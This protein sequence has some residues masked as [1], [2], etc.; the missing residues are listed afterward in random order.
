[1][2]S[3]Q[4]FICMD[5]PTDAN[6][7]V[8]AFRGT[9]AFDTYDWS[10]DFDFSWVKLP[11]LGGVHLGFLEALGLVTREDLSDSV[12]KLRDNA[13]RIRQRQREQGFQHQPS[14]RHQSLD[15]INASKESASGLTEQLIHNRGRS[16]AYDDITH[17]IAVVLHDN[18]N[19]KLFFTGHS[20]GGALACLYGTMLHFM[21]QTEICSKI[22]AVYTFG[23]PRVGDEKFRKY[24]NEKLEGKYFRVVYCNDMVPRIPFDTA[25]MEF[26]HFGECEYFNSVYDGRTLEEEPNPNYF[27][28][29]RMVTMHLNAAWEVFYAMILITWQ[30][31]KEYSESAFSLMSR[32]MGLMVPGVSGHSPT[33]YVNAVR[34]GPFPLRERIKED[35]HDFHMMADN[36]KDIVSCVFL[37][38]LKLLGFHTPKK[39]AGTTY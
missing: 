13:R 19:A 17:E 26:K 31:G 37:E 2:H 32:T 16:L 28:V 12:T 22:G 3:T 14:F 38:T 9:E 27:S 5:K 8:V 11:G 15:Q 34:L 4:A 33:N 30:H 20:L 10:T 6:A 35:I 18:P 39:P 36:F 21:A 25:W 1:M 29:G 24:A 23:Q 7:V